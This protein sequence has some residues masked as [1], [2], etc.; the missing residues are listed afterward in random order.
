[1][2]SLMKNSILKEKMIAFTILASYE[3]FIR[4]KFISKLVTVLARNIYEICL[5]GV[6]MS[7]RPNLT[8][9]VEY[10]KG[11]LPRYVT[12]MQGVKYLKKPLQ[13]FPYLKMSLSNL[14]LFLVAQISF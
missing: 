8:K 12:G 14:K 5:E 4:L 13:L 1:M 10:S 3:D 6:S 11:A 7:T 2:T 9:L